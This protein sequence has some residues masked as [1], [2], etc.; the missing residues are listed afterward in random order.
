MADTGVIRVLIAD[1]VWHYADV[2]RERLEDEGDLEVVEVVG[3]AE[4]AV[5]RAAALRPD[6]VLLDLGL[7]EMGSIEA[8]RRLLENDPKLVV[9]VVTVDDTTESVRESLAA[10]ALSYVVKKDRD[11]PARVAETLRVA[12]RGQVVLDA[13][14]NAQLKEIVSRSHS[15]PTGRATVTVRQREVLELIAEGLGNK[16][17]ATALQISTHTVERHVEN[18]LRKFGATNRTELIAIVRRLHLLP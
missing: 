7:A 8:C 3:S 13:A 11:D 4:E 1:D 14:L 9:V 6:A 17:I 2:L 16:M 12:V 18:L 5:E 15:D 10:G